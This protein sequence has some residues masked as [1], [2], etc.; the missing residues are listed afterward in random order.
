MIVGQR[1]SGKRT[2][3]R[4]LGERTGLPVIHIDRIHRQPGWIERSKEEKSRLCRKAELTDEWIF[5]GGHSA[6]LPSRLQR[7]EMLVWLDRP[8]GLR[9]WRAVRR[10][11]TSL[12]KTR[13][14]TADGCLERLSSLP[15]FIEYI[16][17]TRNSSRKTIARLAAHAPG[18]LAVVPLRSDRQAAEFLVRFGPQPRGPTGA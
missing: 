16:W 9:L 17:R 11:V 7:S 2:L 12:G 18:G 14:D 4:K 6:T 8:I 13:P 5:E 1:G 3:A 10:A 15:E